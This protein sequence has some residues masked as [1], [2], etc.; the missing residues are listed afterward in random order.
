VNVSAPAETLSGQ[1]VEISWV[2]T[3]AGTALVT[4]EFRDRVY[5]A[6]TPTGAGAIEFGVFPF[7]EPIPAGASVPRQQRITLPIDF[8]GTYWVLIVAD[9]ANEVFEHHGETNNTLVAAVP[10]QV[11]LTPTPNLAVSHATAP[12]E[13]FSGNTT[14]VQWG[15]T[16]RGI[17]P[18]SA[19]YWYDAVYLSTDAVLSGNDTYLGQRQNLSF[20]DVG[21]SYLSSLSVSLP[22]GLSG[23]YYL[24][25]RTDSGQQ[26]FEHT[27]E[28]DNVTASALMR[29]TL[30]PP[31]DLQVHEVRPPLNA[32][33]G[34]PA[35]ISWIVTNAGPGQ[36][37]ENRWNDRLWISTN[38][39]I[40]GSARQL[41]VV[42]HVGALD[43]NGFY[44]A[45]NLVLLPS[46]VTG[47]FYVIVT[48]D[49]FN[50]VFENP[51][52]G[53]NDGASTY[54]MRIN[55]TPPP[56]LAI[57]LL[58]APSNALASFPVTVS[59]RVVNEGATATPNFS[60]LDRLYLSLD[61]KLSA[62]D[63]FLNHVGHYGQLKVGE[64]YQRGISG[65]IPNA[66]NGSFYLLLVTD[67]NDEVFEV[68]NTN[69]LLVVGPI[70]IE[71]RPA[72]LVVHS[73]TASSSAIA[74]QSIALTWAV[75]NAGSGRTP[76][77][78]WTDR[79][80]LSADDFF[81]DSDD[82]VLSER[83]RS[84]VLTNGTEYVVTALAEIPITVSPGDYRLFILTD[85]QNE[86]F[87]G[88]NENNNVFGPLAIAITRDTA[89]LRVVSI[90]SPLEATA[91]TN[92]TV[93][94]VVENIGTRVP[95]SAWWVDRIYLSL[96]D[97]LSPDDIDFGA[98]QSFSRL[99]PGQSYTNSLRATTLPTLN[100]NY[101]VIVVT[102]QAGQVF[103][104]GAE[105]NNRLVSTNPTS[106]RPGDVPDLI[107]AAVNA[108]AE[109]FSGQ[110]F[111]LSWVVEN[112]GTATASAQG[113]YDAVYLSPDHFLDRNTDAYV[114]FRSRP[115]QLLPGERYTNSASFTIPPGLAGPF[116]VIVAA[117]AGGN[118]FEREFEDNNLSIDPEAM[119]VTLLP[120][121]DLVAGTITLPA[122][123]RPGQ[124]ITV[125]FSVFNQGSN[126]AR[127]SWNDALYISADTTWDVNDA[128]LGSV[129]HVGDVLGNTGYLSSVTA[130]LPGVLP[131]DYFVIVRSDILNHLV[132]PNE[133]NNIGA[134]LN[135]VNIDAELLT[136]GTPAQGSMVQGQSVF[137]KFNANAG[138]TVR[139]RF[140]TGVPLA[141]AELFV[142]RGQMPTRGQF[143]FAAN[144][145]FLTEPDLIMPVAE[146]G[147][148]YLLAYGTFLPAPAN[149]TVL[150]EVLPFSVATV[151]PQIAG[152]FGETTFEVR[153]ALFDSETVF[154]LVSATNTNTSV[155]VWL[156]DST[157]AFVTFN[158]FAQPIGWR[159]L[160]AAMGTNVSV[161]L[162]NAV[163]VAAGKGP[164]IE[165]AW[166]GPLEV[167][168]AFTIPLL[169]SWGN[170]G[171]AD[172]LAPL[173][174]VE[175]GA[176][177]LAG[178]RYADLRP[179]LLQILGTSLNGPAG[180][181]APRTAHSQQLYYRGGSLRMDAYP[182]MANET[183]PISD[184]DWLRLE[185]SVRPPGSDEAAWDEFW[186]G[187]R[188]RVGS[189]W[190]D[191][192]R[193]LNR[194]SA[195]FPATQRNV[196]EMFASIFTNEPSYRA[197]SFVAGSVQEA[198]TATP[199]ANVEVGLY[200]DV[201]GRF[202]LGGR[203]ITD[204]AG[205]FLINGVAPG[206][207]R[208]AV[209]G[210]VF[211]MNQ[212]GTADS[213]F[214]TVTV[215]AGADIAGQTLHVKAR[216]PLLT[217]TNDANASLVLDAS[218][219]LH[220]FWMRD[221]QVWHAWRNGA[222]WRD[223]QPLTTNV[224]GG[225]AANAGSQL[226]DG[227]DAGL[228][229]VWSEGRANHSD[230]FYA[231]G[232]PQG[233]GYQWSRPVRLTEDQVQDS[234]PAIAI[235]PNGL[236]MVLY[237]KRNA[238]QRDDT[239][240]Y[241]SIVQVSSGD[242][243]WTAPARR[244]PAKSGL[245]DNTG[246]VAF[247]WGGEFGPYN[248]LGIEFGAALELAAEGSITGCDAEAKGEVK[249]SLF[250][251][252]NHAKV[253]GFGSGSIAGAWA[254]NPKTCLWE[255]N[256]MT[257]NASAGV[258][259][260]LPDFAFVVMESVPQPVVQQAA[261][262]LHD[263]FDWVR[264]NTGIR[265]TH[266]VGVEGALD[267][268]G[269]R[270]TKDPAPTSAF[271]LPDSMDSVDGKFSF[272]ID[273]IAALPDRDDTLVFQDDLS[274]SAADPNDTFL[275]ANGKVEF[276]FGVLPSFE[277]KNV[278]G[279]IKFTCIIN[280]WQLASEVVPINYSFKSGQAPRKNGGFLPEGFTF[281]YRPELSVG[282]TN[283]YGSNAVL[284]N[285]RTDLYRDGQ[286]AVA[287]NEAGQPFAVWF[288]EGNPF[289]GF[290]SE[291]VTAEFNGLNWSAPQTLPNSRGFNSQVCA[292]L[293][294]LGQ[295][296]AV[297][298]HADASGISSNTTAE[299]FFAARDAAN[300][301][302]STFNGT[303]WSTPSPI[304]ATAGRDTDLQ[305]SRQTDG[306][307]LAVWTHHTTNT[308]VHLVASRWNGT[309]WS[310]PEVITVGQVSTPTAQQVGSETVVLWTAVVGTNDTDTALFQSRYQS[311]TWGAPEVFDPQ[312]L[313]P[314]APAPIAKSAPAK[315]SQTLL[316][317]DVVPDRCCR[318]EEIRTERE[319][320]T[321]GAC[322]IS[323]TFDVT[324]CIEKLTYQACPRV[325]FDPNDIVGPVGFGPERWV[326]GAQPLGY[327]IR[328]ENDPV[329][330]TAPA[331][332]VT[333]RQQL[334]P[335]LDPRT[336]RL[337]SFGFGDIVVEVPEN[338]AFYSTRLDY[339]A[340]LGFYLD[341]AAGVDVLNREA[342]WQISTIDPATGNLPLNPLLGF[343][344]PNITS[345]EGEGFVTYTIR[346]H[347]GAAQGTRVD[348]A[349]TI[350]FDTEQPIDTPAIF[351]TLEPLV[352]TSAVAALPLVT[353]TPVFMLEW[354]GQDAPG[355]SALAGFDIYMSVNDGAPTLLLGNTPATQ[356]PFAGDFGVTYSFYSVARDNAGN[357]EP[358]P[359]LPDARITIATPNTAPVL[360]IPADTN[361]AEQ[362]AFTMSL[363]ATDNDVPTNTV[364][365][366]LLSGPE[367]LTIASAGVLTW[368]PT[369]AQGPSTN[370][371]VFVG[372][373]NGTPSLSA[374]GT[375]TIIV[376]E[377]NRAPAFAGT[378]I[379][380]LDELAAFTFTN[381][382]VD[383]D[384]P[385]N[386]VTLSAG[387]LPG[388][389]SFDA[390]TGVLTWTPTE[391][392]GPGTNTV[393]I[394]AT[395][396]G[397]PSSN[398]VRTLTLIVR[399]VNSA[400][401][402]D[403]V[404]NVIATPYAAVN[405]S[406]TARDSDR[407]QTNS[408]SFALASNAPPSATID[409]VTGA[410]RWTPGRT[411]AGTSN[412]IA[413]VVTDNG[414]PS[415]SATQTLVVLVEDLLEIS[416]GHAALF[417]GQTS[418]IPIVA[419][420]SSPMRDIA[421][422]FE[423]PA[424]VLGDLALSNVF[425]AFASASI[426][427]ETETRWT[428]TF[429]NAAGQTFSGTQ[430][431]AVLHFR[432]VGSNSIALTL[433]PEAMIARLAGGT[434]VPHIDSVPGR[435][436]VI[437]DR[438]VLDALRS[439]NGVQGLTVFGQPGRSYTIEK[440]TNL[441]PPIVWEFTTNV[442]LTNL[443][444]RVEGLSN[445]PPVIYRARE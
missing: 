146:T 418:S 384:E 85:R 347:N 123:A 34:Q 236:A 439:S 261:R 245:S 433:T 338:S 209:V 321:P 98:R 266:N 41:K 385:S 133:T 13:T 371:V 168:A 39:F 30:T 128:F 264:A 20:L 24:L 291:L 301:V 38:D 283:Q 93:S 422:S 114:G 101:Y 262:R 257:L 71:S 296:L 438:P 268:K 11:R 396:S 192:V 307:V 180:V 355:G 127:G 403:A 72:D 285:V 361:I 293:D 254:A 404:S 329:F 175:P 253:T 35:L 434:L 413:V 424:G 239:D 388:G 67:M 320:F 228:I 336:F 435:I 6:A 135:A 63:V 407:P 278:S 252:R 1:Q 80:V 359:S 441:M 159:D 334:D 162:S 348:A 303:S 147:T 174:M 178:S 256:Q 99:E 49:A 90:Q 440:T 29:I 358:A 305:L 27:N 312:P 97:L 205:Q 185:N 279:S 14:V 380:Y 401:T 222:D 331:K 220:S 247:G 79:V 394:T 10:I 45:T 391:L 73:A 106:I 136:L 187:I 167:W 184:A 31:P 294:S 444:Q 364:S 387:A 204:N 87:E 158:L 354:S 94:W 102:D 111:Q 412:Q 436:V 137:F 437:G 74:G 398:A 230:L 374:T 273:F 392:Q 218:G 370:I 130:E 172:T 325:S 201:D 352:P 40:D 318:C 389:A 144:E 210:R 77:A 32:F 342:F 426:A 188:P 349:A 243:L 373:D 160:R 107:V 83:V 232:R 46:G 78:R 91:G 275:G 17:G 161:T 84:G 443:W 191:Y 271:R 189:T 223:A 319:G 183:K 242:L 345:P 240:L 69:N 309:A 186:A 274:L 211:D 363:S 113:W 365:F 105:A 432:S 427:A 208:F 12:T 28:T 132:E 356:V 414:S 360:R 138:D 193:F 367:G 381:V 26:V 179:G 311:G 56:D 165:V 326:P 399:E 263:A 410:F 86:V 119:T 366:A 282:T 139:I 212:D 322:L 395:D 310:A 149:Y 429:S 409:S 25:V 75:T 103:E 124:L 7:V 52:E 199:I 376:R 400:P 157:R 154:N 405:V 155:R 442:L 173:I 337:G 48:A 207:Y 406:I 397:V 372:T 92:M 54:R 324:N 343:L 288:K 298:V 267:F 126:T 42:E 227:S 378:N 145:P 330:A 163:F 255:F 100:S 332:Q 153:G 265:V 152:N 110:T 216:T 176:G 217:R 286:P 5:L 416:L 61:D 36:T 198:G 57:S 66:T 142:R 233:A 259:L 229:A 37:A 272:G 64:D 375:F 408:L 213:T 112:A 260:D 219:V 284:A 122:N 50:Q 47:D 60:W 269:L 425:P 43:T 280:G 304:S 295:R 411:Y 190:G 200:R 134:S 104:P 246:K 390:N 224:V 51:F 248:A 55:L 214:P 15:V 415:L 231:V 96:D 316:P 196:R 76:V 203:A 351:N 33:S 323:R 315:A 181:I 53:N 250:V 9:S 314:P 420:A 417:T 81:G 313:T 428:V 18:T 206:T 169:L 3:N 131:G 234:A 195:K 4:R 177:T 166:D 120:P 150:A 362:V 225:F 350:I 221:R 129:R 327:M 241:Y 393:T 328:F 299:A 339:T 23:D 419:H 21:E 357:L 341:F 382:V 82:I 238:A 22:R 317:F 116:Y 59:Y 62:E 151:E 117:D 125:N 423:L 88:T 290:G 249:M 19:P 335:D 421:F 277:A 402:I 115:R 287:T 306:S 226:I 156:A 368:T 215:T 143:D 258:R 2:L 333:I 121:V 118:L 251:E 297:W 379:I 44:L 308:E 235:G 270:W 65:V 194:L 182:V 281:T 170:T 377:V 171:D 140:N 430:Q 141:G 386:S 289:T 58:N 292:A 164:Q 202:E 445:P 383:A 344:P 70:T 197:A 109:A 431:L 346:A 68:D 108:P 340:T 244:A 276:V 237:L 369:E 302:F 353:N 16:N 89:D 148:Y 95:E 8:S 300:V